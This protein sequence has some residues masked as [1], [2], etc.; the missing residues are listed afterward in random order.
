MSSGI[1]FFTAPYYSTASFNQALENPTPNDYPWQAWLSR[2]K[3]FGCKIK[4]G[5]EFHLTRLGN[6][7]NGL[8]VNIVVGYDIL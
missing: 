3:S 2:A 6:D 7:V 8:H 5:I 1:L 4:S